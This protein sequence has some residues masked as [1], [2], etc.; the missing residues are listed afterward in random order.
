MEPATRMMTPHTN[1]HR[2][3]V[4]VFI[5]RSSLGAPLDHTA[6]AYDRT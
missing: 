5:T 2:M 4:R 6:F 3:S 1:D